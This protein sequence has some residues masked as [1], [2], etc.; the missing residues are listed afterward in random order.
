MKSDTHIELLK[1]FIQTFKG[2]TPARQKNVQSRPINQQIYDRL[3]RRIESRQPRV[4][5][6]RFTYNVE[7]MQNANFLYNA[8]LIKTPHSE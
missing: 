7:H 1:L 2:L 8:L 4:D 3:V 5:L 6:G